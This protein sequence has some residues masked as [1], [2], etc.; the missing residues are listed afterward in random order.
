MEQESA[1]SEFIDQQIA[2]RVQ[3]IR[4]ARKQMDL[5]ETQ[6]DTLQNELR[7]LIEQKGSGWKDSAGYARLIVEGERIAYD[8]QALDELILKEPLRY[9]WLADFRKRATLR[10]S[11][12]IK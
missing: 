8:T 7:E 6:V 10:G 1:L 4:D 11:V 9:G 3:I 12:Q 2:D 5:L